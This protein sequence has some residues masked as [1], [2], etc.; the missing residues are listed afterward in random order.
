MFDAVCGNL[1][2]PS[3]ECVS[4]VVQFIRFGGNASRANFVKLQREDCFNSLLPM[5]DKTTAET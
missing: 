3:A 5:N 1:H 2:I 4:Y